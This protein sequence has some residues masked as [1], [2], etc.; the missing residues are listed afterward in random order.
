MTCRAMAQTKPQFAGDRGGDDVGR[1]AGAGEPA[2]ACAQPHLS[3][4]GDLADRFGLVFLA[5]PQL[6]ADPRWEAVAPRR[7]DQQPACG[8]VAG[9][10]DA[11]TSDA[12]AAR[13]FGRHQPR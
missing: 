2:I 12:G 5:Q 1:L 13:M 4:P 6:A 9:F 10:G 11:A 7:F 3:L 8:A